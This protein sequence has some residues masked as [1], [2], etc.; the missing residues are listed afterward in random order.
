[1]CVCVF[2]NVCLRWCGW[3]V[4]LQVEFQNKMLCFV[5][6]F[7]DGYVFLYWGENLLCVLKYVADDGV[8]CVWG[9]GIL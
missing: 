1:M 2:F 7:L 9:E 6:V 8:W 3:C 5:F 4:F